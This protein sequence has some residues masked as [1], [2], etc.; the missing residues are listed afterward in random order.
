MHPRHWLI[1]KVCTYNKNMS[2]LDASCSYSPTTSCSFYAVTRSTNHFTA[3]S[4]RP[5]ILVSCFMQGR[6][7]VAARDTHAIVIVIHIWEQKQGYISPLSTIQSKTNNMWTPFMADPVRMHTSLVYSVIIWIFQFISSHLLLHHRALRRLRPS[8]GVLR[9]YRVINHG[10]SAA[11]SKSEG[12]RIY[13]NYS[14]YSSISF[15][16]IPQFRDSTWGPAPRSVVGRFVDDLV[17]IR[18]V[19]KS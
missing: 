12:V 7:W 2:W 3:A 18:S 9:V 17:I 13:R 5:T 8:T 14:E 1:K 10:I 16:T 4:S 19:R 11:I 15:P 6:G